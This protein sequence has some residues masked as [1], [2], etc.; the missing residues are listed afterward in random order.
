MTSYGGA[1]PNGLTIDYLAQRLY[2]TD[3]RS[4]SIHTTLYD[5]SGHHEVIRGHSKLSHP[6]SVAVFESHVYWTDWRSSSVMR[7]NKWN[8]SD[9][10]VIERTSSKPY[11]IKVIHPSL[12]PKANTTH[13]CQIRNGDCS[14]LCLL[15]FE[16]TRKCGCPH[17][18]K[19]ASDGVTCIENKVI[20]HLFD[21]ES[22]SDIRN[23]CVK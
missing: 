14:H 13:P 22:L 15:G 2:W 11:G 10:Q 3:A 19:L 18:M 9:V 8:G 16:N 7:A 21:I 5:G 23:Q 1:W 17:I 12:Q 4:D 6:F 20:L